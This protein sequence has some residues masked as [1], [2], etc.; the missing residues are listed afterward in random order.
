MANSKYEPITAFFM[1]QD[2]RNMIRLSFE[3]VEQ[4]IGASLAPTARTDRTWWGNTRNST[5][6]QARAWLVAGWMVGTVDF[7][8]GVVEFVRGVPH[9]KG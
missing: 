5:R 2:D 1:R 6:T 9:Y 8:A 3:R 7:G 4:I